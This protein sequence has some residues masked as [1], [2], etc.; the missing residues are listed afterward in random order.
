MRWKNSY[1]VWQFFFQIPFLLHAA[2][3][4]NT[5]PTTV[6]KVT[7]ESDILGHSVASVM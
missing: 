1:Y 5:Y 2:Y 3:K 4:H 6:T 7:Q